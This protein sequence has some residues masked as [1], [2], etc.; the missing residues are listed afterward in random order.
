MPCGWWRKFS[1]AYEDGDEGALRDF[2][3]DF[4]EH[5]GSGS[6]HPLCPDPCTVDLMETH[7]LYSYREFLSDLRPAQLTAQAETRCKT[8]ERTNCQRGPTVIVSSGSK[9]E[10]PAPKKRKTS[11]TNCEASMASSPEVIVVEDKE[12]PAAVEDLR[13]YDLG[14]KVPMPPAEPSIAA[15]PNNYDVE[16]EPVPPAVPPEQQASSSRTTFDDPRLLPQLRPHTSLDSAFVQS[17]NPWPL[18]APLLWTR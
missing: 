3:V 1:N 5:P 14:D 10:G 11:R 8:A 9:E 4:W 2:E 18:T 6:F 7:C 17:R 13:N 12:M 15:D 16:L